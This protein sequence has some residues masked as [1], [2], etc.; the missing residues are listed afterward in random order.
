MGTGT[1]DFFRLFMMPGVLH[2]QGGLGPSQFDSMTPLV[3]WVE[4]G[5]AP[6]RLVASLKQ[7]GKTIRS[8]PLCGYPAVAKFTEG[9]NKDDA[10]SFVCSPPAAPTSPSPHRNP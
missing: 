1:G 2:C 7:D 4:R 10:A 9:G 5:T 8:R 3:D 6:D